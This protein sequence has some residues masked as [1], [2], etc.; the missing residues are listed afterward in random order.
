MFFLND[1]KTSDVIH[2][3]NFLALIFLEEINKEYKPDSLIYIESGCCGILKSIFIF[4]NWI[5]SLES[6]WLIIICLDCL[7]SKDTHIC[8]ALNQIILL[9]SVITIILCF[10]KLIVLKLDVVYYAKHIFKSLKKGVCM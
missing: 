7:Y 10:S 6:T 5:L 2:F 8:L 1:G 3:V 4:F 9:L